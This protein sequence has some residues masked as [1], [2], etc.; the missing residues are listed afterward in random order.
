[1][2][3]DKIYSSVLEYMCTNY[4]YSLYATDFNMR[5]VSALQRS[6]ASC[7]TTLSGGRTLAMK[8]ALEDF[9]DAIYQKAFVYED[10]DRIK[11]V[12]YFD[13]GAVT[14]QEDKQI[15]G[16]RQ[17]LLSFKE[18]LEENFDKNSLYMFNKSSRKR[19]ELALISFK[20]KLRKEIIREQIEIVYDLDSRDIVVFLNEK[21]FVKKFKYSNSEE[22][23]FEEAKEIL[24]D[25]RFV[26][27]LWEEARLKLYN[28]FENDF[29]FVIY[30]SK[31][32]YEKYPN[33]FFSILKLVVKNAFFKLNDDD[34]GKYTNVVFKN[35]IPKMLKEVTHYLFGQV[36]E[37]NLKAIKF[38]KE[39][40][41]STRM[42]DDKMKLDR[43]PLIDSVGKIYK[44]Q[45]ILTLLKKKE[46]VNSKITHKNIEIKSIQK[47]IY[48][49][50]KIV[51][52]SEDEMEAIQKRRLSLLVAIEKVEDDIS[53]LNQKKETKNI[54]INRLEF[55][56]RDLL[57]AFKQVEVRS[58]TQNNILKNT[59]IELD[60]WED[61]K[62]EKVFLQ[63]ELVNEQNEL[64]KEYDKLCQILAASLGKEQIKF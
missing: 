36:I 46:L 18:E 11:I 30:D 28:S 59:H 26:E 34:V 60:R 56:K 1:M 55:T 47:R 8:T 15:H 31:E 10:E 61:K 12:K 5:Y 45:N 25:R 39:Y 23:I 17:E 24:Y 9:F 3:E 22:E 32:F 53:I 62:N 54:D 37:G 6:I 20:E 58:H 64:L 63:G 57:E 7:S 49:S 14:E 27:S 16:L 13:N 33:K 38:L 43:A 44:Y 35:Y 42:L 19:F 51:Q 29:N 50:L 41:E 48:K 21:I 2:A 40:S 52:G 4:D